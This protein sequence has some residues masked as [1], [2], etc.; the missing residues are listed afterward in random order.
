MTDNRARCLE[1][2]QRQL[3]Q[4]LELLC[5]ALTTGDR[6]QVR[7]KRKVWRFACFGQSGKVR[8]SGKSTKSTKQHSNHSSRFST[9][10]FYVWFLLVRPR[11]F[12]RALSF[13]AKASEGKTLLLMKSW[14]NKTSNNERWTLLGILFVMC[15]V[16]SWKKNKCRA[17]KSWSTTMISC[18]TKCDKVWQ[19]Q[20]LNLRSLRTLRSL[21]P[22]CM[23]PVPIELGGSSHPGRLP[24]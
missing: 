20:C 18:L 21:R 16:Y 10:N 15:D 9:Q 19:S 23:L 14:S 24:C 1:P 6:L 2:F 7:Y 13:S 4:L 17:A 3:L 8:Q 12:S 22:Y 5:P 11:S